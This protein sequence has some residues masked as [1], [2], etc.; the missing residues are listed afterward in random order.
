MIG[1]PRGEMGAIGR[2]S[3]SDAKKVWKHFAIHPNFAIIEM[4]L[5]FQ[6]VV[7]ASDGGHFAR[8]GVGGQNA[9]R[10]RFVDDG[11]GLGI[12]LIG[13]GAIF[14][15]HGGIELL[16]S[17]L[18]TRADGSVAFVFFAG[19]EDTFLLRFDISQN[20]YLLD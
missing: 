19:N 8:S 6:R 9:G 5:C 20:K 1:E 4:K 10:V 12:E 16:D 3:L 15:S 18:H 11:H 14:G 13:Q 2:I 7:G 17:I